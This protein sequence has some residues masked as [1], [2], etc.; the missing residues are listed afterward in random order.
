MHQWRLLSVVGLLAAGLFAVSAVF[1]STDEPQHHPHNAH[2][3]HC[4][5]ACADCM[6]TC[7]ACARHCANLVAEGQ[8]DH[9]M[10][11]GTCTDCGDI[12][13]AAAK[14]VAREGPLSIVVCEACAKVCNTCGAACEKF[15]NDQHMT[16]CAK[17][18]REC[19]KACQQMVD[20]AKG[21][22]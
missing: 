10:T 18:C 22:K 4:A 1:S 20:A 13:G 17:T 15:P 16:E 6:R 3:Q 2:M 11:L 19:E 8:K 9:M 21:N 12:C 14:I 7:E 5:K